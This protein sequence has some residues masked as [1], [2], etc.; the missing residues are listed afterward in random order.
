MSSAVI[1]TL[2]ILAM[3]ASA[4][5]QG[6]PPAVLVELF[7]SQGCSSCPPADEALLELKASAG[8]AGRLTRLAWHV[9]Y[10][11]NLG[12][13]DPFSQKEFS[14]RQR[15]Y[16]KA[17][18]EKNLWTPQFRVNGKSVRGIAELDRAIQAAQREVPTITLGIG[19]LALQGDALSIEIG[20]KALKKEVPKSLSLSIA[21]VEN[22]LSTVVR[23]ARTPGG[24]SRKASWPGF[25]CRRN[26]ALW[27]KER[28]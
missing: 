6:E 5:D 9:D 25:P 17:F 26:R 10:W 14:E 18:A 11:N 8:D 27:K 3:T 19:N 23:R 1:K 24:R 7:T 12:W 2:A 20:V 15:G 28:R 16:A 22:E 13:T 4:Q 21:L